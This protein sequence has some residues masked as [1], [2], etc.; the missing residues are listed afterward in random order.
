MGAELEDDGAEVRCRSGC[1]LLTKKLGFDSA[2]DLCRREAET[3]VVQ[4]VA[5][6][7]VRSDAL[8]IL[9]PIRGSRIGARHF[10]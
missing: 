4:H 5:Q 9:S 6:G 7:R 2:T 10:I 3:N 1:I 8:N